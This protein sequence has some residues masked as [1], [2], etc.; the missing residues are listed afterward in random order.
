MAAIV[1]RKSKKKVVFGVSSSSTISDTS[2]IKEAFLLTGHVVY[3]HKTNKAHTFELGE[4]YPLTVGESIRFILKSIRQYRTLVFKRDGKYLCYGRVVGKFGEDVY[5]S[6]MDISY[7]VYDRPDF[8][9]W[10]ELAAPFF[11]SKVE[12][13]S[14]LFMKGRE[15]SGVESSGYIFRAFKDM[16][17]DELAL[18]NN[19]IK[20]GGQRFHLRVLPKYDKSEREFEEIET[21]Q[22]QITENMAVEKSLDAKEGVA[23]LN[24]PRKAKGQLVY[25]EGS[26][27][28]SFR[29]RPRAGKGQDA[30]TVNQIERNG[31][32]VANAGKSLFA[33]EYGYM[34]K[35]VRRPPSSRPPSRRARRGGRL[36]RSRRY[37][38]PILDEVMGK[39]N[40]KLRF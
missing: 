16:S 35:G 37:G 39:T 15:V 21:L 10:P 9:W 40:P 6:L 23:V 2:P 27:S 24:A 4:R 34:P 20:K 22:R 12:P 8:R 17:K 11:I 7:V 19:F 3:V 13:I 32:M 5:F 1:G 31:R 33:E 25:D 28:P 36:T 18:A 30:R 26:L 38:S 14:G 29:R